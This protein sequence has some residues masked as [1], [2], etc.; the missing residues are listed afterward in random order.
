[1]ARWPRPLRVNPEPPP[2]TAT[3]WSLGCRWCTSCHTVSATLSHCLCHTVCVTLFLTASH[4]RTSSLP[5]AQCV[6]RCDSH[7]VSVMLSRT[8]CLYHTVSVW[9]RTNS[10]LQ[11][12]TELERNGRQVSCT[13]L[14]S[15]SLCYCNSFGRRM[16]MT[17]SC[18]HSGQSGCRQPR[19]MQR[20]G[21]ASSAPAIALEAAAHETACQSDSPH[22]SSNL[23]TKISARSGGIK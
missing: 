3:T 1:M 22:V 15:V 12:E 14:G 19:T 21:G 9:L 20:G 5:L 6:C 4:Y 11:Y 2:C 13:G 18:T 17:C 7:T 8:H 10:A 16:A 23:G